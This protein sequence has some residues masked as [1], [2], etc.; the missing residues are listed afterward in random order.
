MEVTL[1]TSLG[2]VLEKKEI[3]DKKSEFRT[4]VNKVDKIC[5]EL[6]VDELKNGQLSRLYLGDINNG[7]TETS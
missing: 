1:L 5:I 2:T 4:G 6:T 3:R 7:K